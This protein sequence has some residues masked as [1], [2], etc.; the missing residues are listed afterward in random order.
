MD[1]RFTKLISDNESQEMGIQALK[2]HE[3][4]GDIDESTL[5]DTQ[6]LVPHKYWEY[7]D[8]FSKSK[9]EH[10]PLRKSWDHGIDLK[11]DFPLKKG[12]LIPLSV[13]EQSIP[14]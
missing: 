1:T 8:V 4:K 7:L 13:D 6:K 5:A 12:R 10:M 14:G 3:S 2:N 9:S 11:E